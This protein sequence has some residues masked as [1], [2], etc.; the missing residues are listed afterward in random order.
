MSIDTYKITTF[1]KFGP[2]EQTIRGTKKG[3]SDVV[4]QIMM[5]DNYEY[6]QVELIR[7]D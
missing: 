3:V 5:D 6:F 4:E 1:G 2:T 7:G